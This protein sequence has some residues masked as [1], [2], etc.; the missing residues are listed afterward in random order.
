MKVVS[1]ELILTIV[2][3]VGLGLVGFALYTFAPEMTQSIFTYM[4]NFFAK[5]PMPGFISGFGIGNFLS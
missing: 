3:I 5:S 4:K 2:G 1:G